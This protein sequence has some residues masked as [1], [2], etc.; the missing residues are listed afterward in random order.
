M[1]RVVVTQLGKKGQNTGQGEDE[2]YR[3]KKNIYA[4]VR[5]AHEKR[6]P[7]NISA[8]EGRVDPSTTDGAIRDS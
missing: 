8:A 5:R 1:Y 4:A 7:A 6:R 2:E 3:G